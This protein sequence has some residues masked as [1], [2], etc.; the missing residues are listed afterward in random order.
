MPVESDLKRA[1]YFPC[2]DLAASWYFDRAAAVINDW[3]EQDVAT[4]NDAIEV[5]QC[6]LIAENYGEYLAVS[7]DSLNSIASDL[8]GAAC[9]FM[10]RLL[11]TVDK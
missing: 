2:S 4:V 11:G 1:E 3:S 8:F 7:E 10:S 9:R 5:Y 6:K